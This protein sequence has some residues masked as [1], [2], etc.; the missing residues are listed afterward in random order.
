MLKIDTLAVSLCIIGALA[1]CGG[2]ATGTRVG[3]PARLDIISGDAQTAPAGTQLPTPLVVRVTDAS[4]NLVPRQIVNFVVTSG[5]GSVFAPATVTNSSGT[6]QDLWTLGTS[7]TDAQ[8]VEARAVDPTTGAALVFATFHATVAAG[9]AAQLIKAAGDAQTGYMTTVLTDSLEVKVLDRYGNPAP[10]VTVTWTANDGGT[11]SPATSATR[12]D[13]TARAAWILG[14]QV[15]ATAT[16]SVAGLPGVTFAATGGLTA[17]IGASV[18]KISGD[19]QTG[20]AGTALAQPLVVSVKLPDGRPV[21]GIDPLFR[22]D[23]GLVAVTGQDGK[24]QLTWTLGHTA[25]QETIASTASWITQPVSFTETVVAGPPASVLVEPSGGSNGMTS[26]QAPWIAGTAFTATFTSQGYLLVPLDSIRATVKDQFGNACG[27]VAVTWSAT[28]G[29]A[30][31]AATTTGSDGTARTHFVAGIQNQKSFAY[32]RVGALVDSGWVTPAD[33]ASYASL[34]VAPSSLTVAAGSTA[35]L[36]IQV[37]DQAGTT[38]D[39]DSDYLTWTSSDTTIATASP[40]AA[41]RPAHATVIARAPGTVTL[42]GAL[43][44]MQATVSV[45]VTP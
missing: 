42:T 6:A 1:G 33:G 15:G 26:V 11:L 30:R 38:F 35:D 24:T 43:F 18:T 34:V 39:V 8:T 5:G 44:S 36:L 28:N 31:P 37:R 20:A 32:A 29:V 9:S 17:A 22:S 7:T 23:H 25:G 14:N 41:G 21:V 3:P 45:T 10:N 12:A 16:A 13:G 2:E 19:G 4:G 27:G 40:G